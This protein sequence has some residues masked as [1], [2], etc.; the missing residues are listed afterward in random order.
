MGDRHFQIASKVED[1]KVA[2]VVDCGKQTGVSGMPVDI[3][4]VVL[5]ILECAQRVL[6]V[7]VPQLDGPVV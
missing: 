4:D 3:V 7:G 6:G 1:I 5:G 2:V